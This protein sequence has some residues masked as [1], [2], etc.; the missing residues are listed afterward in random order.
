MNYL[1]EF[2]ILNCRIDTSWQ[3]RM[4]HKFDITLLRPL[5]VKSF[6]Y[7]SSYLQILVEFKFFK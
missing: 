7:S 3:K 1:F 4:I 5:Q 6:N 2:E